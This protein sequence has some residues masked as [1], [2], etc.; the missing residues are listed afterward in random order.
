MIGRQHI[1]CGF[2]NL[3]ALDSNKVYISLLTMRDNELKNG[4]NK[5]VFAS[6]LKLQLKYC[7]LFLKVIA[8]FFPYFRNIEKIVSSSG[9]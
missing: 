7:L 8:L 4:I 6:T 5:T 3:D 2:I 9:I 1:A